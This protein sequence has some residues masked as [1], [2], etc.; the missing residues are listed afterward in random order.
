[1][2]KDSTDDDHE[3][4]FAEAQLDDLMGWPVHATPSSAW[5]PT[6]CTIITLDGWRCSMCGTVCV[7]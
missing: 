6:C 5:C 4:E 3:I 1:V 2:V 7:C